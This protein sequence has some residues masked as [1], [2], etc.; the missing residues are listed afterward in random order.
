[1]QSKAFNE[2]QENL[3]EAYKQVADVSMENAANEFRFSEAEREIDLDVSYDDRVSDITVSRDGSWQKRG[4]SSLNGVV[5]II[6]SDSAKCL[7]YRVLSKT[8]NACKSWEVRKEAEPDL[9]QKFLETHDCSIN[10]EGS[11]GSME[12]S[13][14]VECFMTSERKRKLRYTHYIGDGDSKTHSEIVKNDPYNELTVEKLECVGHVQKRVGARLRKLKNTDKAKLSD[15]KPLGGKSC[16]T[17]KVINKL[18]NYFGLAIRQ[19]SGAS[20]YQLK[21]AVGAVL[22]HCSEANDL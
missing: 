7:D 13:G 5:T 18:Q 22:F 3:S 8:C 2:M 12:S 15:G 1:M 19:C 20:V 10:H 21:K 14:I 16:L 4:H 6:A 9:Y 11:S 17:E